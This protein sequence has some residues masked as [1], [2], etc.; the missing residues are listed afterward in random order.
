MDIEKILPNYKTSRRWMIFKG[1]AELEW[2]KDDDNSLIING[3][4]PRPTMIVSQIVIETGVHFIFDG[5]AELRQVQE[6]VY[7]IILT[8]RHF[9]GHADIADIHV[10]LVN[11]PQQSLEHH[12][13]KAM[14]F[15]RVEKIGKDIAA[16]RLASGKPATRK[17]FGRVASVEEA[18]TSVNPAM[19]SCH[20]PDSSIPF[21]SLII[22]IASFL[23]DNNG[24][25]IWRFS[26]RAPP[27]LLLALRG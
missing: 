16:D 21:T 14:A 23:I 26:F 9:C 8:C 1:K 22:D 15:G 10:L 4:F 24:Q 7:A 2:V 18:D 17:M 3:I 11:C 5:D 19:A 13:L 12:I 6:N 27:S 25:F 20:V